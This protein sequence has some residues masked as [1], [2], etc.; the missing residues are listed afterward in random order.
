VL[1]GDPAARL[2][3]TQRAP[4]ERAAAPRAARPPTAR[5]AKEMEKAVLAKLLG[6]ELP[7][8][9]ARRAGVDKAELERWVA[10]YQEAGCAALE[11]IG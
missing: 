7:S 1:L 8:A 2:A 4:S 3:I 5:N 9:I 6:K 11:K 10:V